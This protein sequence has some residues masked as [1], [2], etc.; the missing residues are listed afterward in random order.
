MIDWSRITPACPVREVE[1]ARKRVLELRAQIA[2]RREERDAAAARVVELEREDRQRM[3][4]LL[5][6][7][8]SATSNIVDVERAKAAAG[9]AVRTLEALN[10]AIEGA[11]Q[12]LHTIL[13]KHR[14]SWADR[15]ERDVVERRARAEEAL[16]ALEEALDDLKAAHSVE[17]WLRPGNGLDRE[18][19]PPGGALIPPP[20]SAAV[21]GNR[22]PIRPET[23]VSWLREAIEP[24]KPKPP[25][26]SHPLQPVG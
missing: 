8:K 12:H 7:G 5:A 4:K 9:G 11:E 20:S 18:Q 25:V 2:Q 26:E 23:L 15:A 6:A 16:S 10:L 14:S 17:H 19:R 3:A 22:E 21:T 13:L 1:A 24:A